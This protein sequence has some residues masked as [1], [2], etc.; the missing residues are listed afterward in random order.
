MSDEQPGLRPI[1]SQVPKIVDMQS[2][3]ASTR[4]SSPRPSETG[5]SQSLATTPNAIGTRHGAH[6]AVA[7]LP[8]ELVTAL[9]AADPEET[10][11]S[12]R[13]LLPLSVQHS[14]TCIER[15]WVDPEY[16]MDFEVIGYQL[17][18]PVSEMAKAISRDLI[19]AA[20]KP[21]TPPT[22]AQELARLRVMTKAR[23]I[24]DDLGLLF[25]ALREEL[26]IFAP[27]VVRASLRKIARR[28]KFFPSLAEIRDQCQRAS[29]YRW[30][31]ADAL[32]IDR[33]KDD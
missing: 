22:I 27:D 3:K 32:S 5:G 9:A 11:D 12:L 2:A 7:K 33:P 23:D 15:T 20:L 1:G 25:G 28:E 10:D 14:L 6:G 13:A 19:T 26:S 24:G 30:H 8:D 21:A 17:S 4:T 18:K 31:L 29:R 16:G